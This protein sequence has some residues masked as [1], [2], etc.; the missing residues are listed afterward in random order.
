MTPTA[1][2]KPKLVEKDYGTS[3]VYPSVHVALGLIA[4]SPTN[5]RAEASPELIASIKQDGVTSDILLR[6][7]VATEEHVILAKPNGKFS[8]GQDI[9][10]IVFGERRYWGSAA[11]S[12]ETVPAKIRN[13]SDTEALRLQIDENEQRENLS[14]MDRAAAYEHLR[15]QFIKDHEGERGYTDSKCIH[16]IAEDRGVEARTVYQ[17]LALNKLEL[18]V[19]YAL[20][21]DGEMQV[22]HAY[23]LCRLEGPQQL[24]VL[25]WL[26]KETQHSQ[27]DVPSVRRLKRQIA[28]MQVG[29]DNKKRQAELPLDE[30]FAGKQEK[31]QTSA[32]EQEQKQEI[33]TIRAGLAGTREVAVH[34]PKPLTRAQIKTQNE[35]LAREKK[36]EEKQKLKAEVEQQA[37]NTAM[38]Q[39]AR[40]AKLDRALIDAALVDMISVGDDSPAQFAVR[41]LG[42]PKS[43]WDH[44]SQNEIGAIAKK[45]VPKLKPS[46][47]AALFIACIVGNDLLAYRGSSTEKLEAM[48]RRY[49]VNLPKIRKEL[50]AKAKAQAKKKGAAA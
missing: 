34:K 29:W 9:Y 47:V 7:V 21:N 4:P 41:F 24:E 23:E 39:V 43:R 40:K 31:A 26:R 8:P 49:K 5:R 33:K 30:T 10:E 2:L 6:P 25:A 48:A 37:R 32:E 15:K 35:F 12:L 22:S 45:N 19:Q 14:P 44:F 18:F 50:L 28:E 3:T 36:Q 1:A 38:D 42:W 11:N 17:V 13:L 46:Q 20:R 27:G 16:D